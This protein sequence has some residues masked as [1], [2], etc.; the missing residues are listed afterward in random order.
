[1]AKKGKEPITLFW[2]AFSLG[3]TGNISDCLREF[4]SFQARKDLQYPVNAALL[5]FHKKATSVDHETVASL[6]SELSIA[7]DVTKEAGL[8]LAA[9]FYLFIGNY[10]E[11]KR[12]SKRITDL[13]RGSNTTTVYDVEAYL[14]EQWCN[15]EEISFDWSSPSSSASADNRRVL[16]AIDNTFRNNKSPDFQDTDAL[17]LWARSK[18]LLGQQ[19]DCF[20]VLNQI[21]SLFPNFLPAMADKALLLASM[22]DWEQALDAAQ[23][24][25][26]SDQ[27]NIDSLLIIAVHA[28]TQESQ[29]HDAIEKFESLD[30]ATGRREPAS[31]DLA[32]ETAT[33]F[34]SICN[35]QPR[36]LQYCA[37]QLERVLQTSRG[38]KSE[39]EA[40][41]YSELGRIYLM[42][43]I[44][45]FDKAMRAFREG[46]KKDANNLKVLMGLIL[47][48]LC[49]GAYEDAESQM[50]LLTMMHNNLDDLGYEMLYLQSIIAKHNKKTQKKEQLQLLSRC[51]DL[52]NRSRENSVELSV[53]QAFL[54]GVQ[55][56][57]YLRNFQHLMALNADFSI[58]LALEFFHHI[59]SSSVAN[60]I[61]STSSLLAPAGSTSSA[62]SEE[63]QNPNDPST[64]T[65]SSPLDDGLLSVADDGSDNAAASFG[66][67][68]LQ[69]IVQSCPGMM[70]AYIE[71]ARV[72][73][74]FGKHSD[75]S[76]VLQ[77]CLSLQPQSAAVLIALALVEAG[78]LHTGQANRL[79]E[80]ALAADFSIRT[81]PRFRLVKAIVRAQQVRVLN[82][83]RSDVFISSSQGK[84][85]EALAEMEQLMTGPE[86]SAGR[87]G[88]ATVASSSSAP[89]VSHSSPAS[90]GL[91]SYS[92]PFRLTEDDRVCAYVSYAAMLS[93]ERRMKEANKVLSQ[94]KVIFAGSAQE[95]QVLIAASQLYVEKGDFDA[96]IRMLDKVSPESPSFS[97]AQIAKADIILKHNHDKE[98]FTKC[99]MTLVER[100]PSVSH[101]ILLGDAYLKILN[102]DSAI[103]ALERAYRQDP[104]NTRLRAK[105][106]RALIATHEYHRA[107]E[108]Y[109]SALREAHRTSTT[110]SSSSSNPSDTLQLSHDLAKLYL[111]LGKLR[112]S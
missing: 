58:V 68:L 110:S 23:R 94:A 24:V 25:L 46:T 108:F 18:F 76:R 65:N 102:P 81:I 82:L 7:E 57:R 63:E 83:F 80:Q 10:S 79:L 86:F 67:Q 92:D 8:V 4:E 20:A 107:V 54:L 12:L 111:K 48:Q 61:P 66:L 89:D 26:D 73:F 70:V 21:I 55:K 53:D 42:Q 15:I 3:M 29:P 27:E 9:R 91:T 101:L 74:S 98:G 40:R 104:A 51:F 77:Q 100:D 99:F 43:G 30:K 45:S 62:S 52:F 38:L 41:I 49:E 50:E 22:G 105:I 39:A 87:Q 85:S 19:N 36:A 71:I 75:A 112:Y 37:R 14:I 56:P 35:R 109:E 96:A 69:S 5:H 6:K 31:V 88:S 106:G 28:F 2:H 95:V 84:F 1:M 78:R 33:L 97:K 90:T 47:C 59:E 60:L 13:N 16:S 32:L 72:H 44:S 64:A 11:A 17:M 34:S 103:D 93:K